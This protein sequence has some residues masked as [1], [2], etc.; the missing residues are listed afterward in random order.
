MPTEKLLESDL[1]TMVRRAAKEL[2]VLWLKFTPVGVRG[3]PDRIC[4][5]PNGKTGWLELKAPGKKP[6]KLQIQR[7]KELHTLGHTADCVDNLVEAIDFI[8]ALLPV[9]ISTR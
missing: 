4:I 3:Y 8:K 6:S 5:A 7:I 9:L 1:E 2:N